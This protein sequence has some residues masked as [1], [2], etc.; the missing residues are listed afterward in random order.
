MKVTGNTPPQ[1]VRFGRPIPKMAFQTPQEEEEEEEERRL[2]QDLDR[3]ALL[4]VA[5]RGAG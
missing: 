4:A 3:H 5:W 2:I 1:G